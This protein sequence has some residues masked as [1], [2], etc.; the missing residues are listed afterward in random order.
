MTLWKPKYPPRCEKLVSSQSRSPGGALSPSTLSV[1]QSLIGRCRFFACTLVGTI[2]VLIPA[3]V[4]HAEAS[5]PSS[6]G[7]E[8]LVV[9]GLNC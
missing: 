1:M 9:G 8:T 3:I 4:A 5:L 2:A 6:A 7:A